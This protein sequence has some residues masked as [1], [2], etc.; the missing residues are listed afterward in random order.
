MAA[1]SR[2][3]DALTSSRSTP[4][5]CGSPA[6]P[7]HFSYTTVCAKGL[8]GYVIGDARLTLAKQ[9]KDA[10]D[11]LL[12]DAFSSD[13]VPAHLLTVEALRGYLTHLKP[14]G[15]LILHLSNRHLELLAPAM[16]AAKAA[17]GV[18][19]VQRYSSPAGVPVLSQSSEDVVI[20][21]RGDAGLAPS[22]TMSAGTQA[23][24]PGPSPGPTTT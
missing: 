14:D 7:A 6:T 17:G 5:S 16:A 20:V 24:P 13:S 2:P 12:I 22:S 11:I 8:V 19:M 21:A 3:G 1:Y 18:S 15:V 23:I 10:F 9:P 4:W